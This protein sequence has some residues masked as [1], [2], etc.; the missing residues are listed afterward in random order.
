MIVINN[1]KFA[2]NDSEFTDSLFKSGGTCIGYYKPLKNQIKLFD[3][4]NNLVG[5]ITKHKVLAKA[6][7]QDNGKYWYSY[8]TIDII[9]EHESYRQQINDIEFA[10][11]QLKA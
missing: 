2:L 8:G 7:K 10:L 9:G 1:K 11:E 3:M 6:T 4:N 5:S